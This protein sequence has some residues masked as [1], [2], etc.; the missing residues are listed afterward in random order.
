MMEP[1]LHCDPQSDHLLPKNVYPAFSEQFRAEE[2]KVISETIKQLTEQQN[3][4]VNIINDLISQNFDSIKQ[5]IEF[6]QRREAFCKTVAE[7]HENL[8]QDTLNQYMKLR[9]NLA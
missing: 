4:L 5:T 9:H 6:V 7:V 2:R 8:N 1:A 3:Q